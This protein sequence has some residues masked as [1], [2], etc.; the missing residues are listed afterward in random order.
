MNIQELTAAKTDRK[1]PRVI[2]P[3]PNNTVPVAVRLMEAGEYHL[4]MRYF[5][6]ILFQK[7][8]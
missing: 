8:W 4:I 7:K 2:I 6:M 5:I 1:Y 3:D